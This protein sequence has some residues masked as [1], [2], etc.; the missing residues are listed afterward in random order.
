MAATAK[1]GT[2]IFQGL[3]TGTTYMK[4]FLN[5]DVSLALVRWDAG[6]GQPTTATTGSDF[7]TFDEPVS[8]VDLSL[9]TGVVDTGSLRVVAN[10]VPSG[11]VFLVASHLNT[12]NNRPRINIGFKANTRIGLMSALPAA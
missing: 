10:N 12:L 8:L 7:V 4:A 1:G 5:T 3:S 6:G 2:A 11:H 9:V